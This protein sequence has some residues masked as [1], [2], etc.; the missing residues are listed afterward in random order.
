[1]RE[2]VIIGLFLI[3]VIAM[4]FMYDRYRLEITRHEECMVYATERD[5]L[6]YLDKEKHERRF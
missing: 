1:M 3:S 5:C 6:K 4:F 2:W